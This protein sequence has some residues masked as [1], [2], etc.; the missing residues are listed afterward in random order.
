MA[1]ALPRE[2]I[3]CATASRILHRSA[4]G[5]MMDTSSNGTSAAGSVPVRSSWWWLIEL[6]VFAAVLV[7]D[8][9]HLVPISNTPFLFVLA[10]VS[11]RLRGL[12]WPAVGFSWPP[13]IAHAIAIGA[14]VGI[15]MEL[16]A[17]FA[18]EPLLAAVFDAPPDLSDLRAVVGNLKLLGVLLIFNWTLAAFGEELVYRGYLMNRVAGIAGGGR[19]AWISSLILVSIVFGCAHGESQGVTGIAMEAWNGLLLGI[20]YLASGRR[21]AYPII[22]HGVSNTLAFVM[23]YLGRYP[24]V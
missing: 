13:R 11:L 17:I 22:A 18:I 19:G 1:Q 23:I 12:R 4:C 8:R 6:S 16:L 14:A 9:Y 7:A 21:L 5:A 15:A 2:H 20:L 3:R 24:G 10:W